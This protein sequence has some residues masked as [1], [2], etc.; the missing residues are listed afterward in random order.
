MKKRTLST[1][2]TLLAT[3]S[4]SLLSGNVLADNLPLTFDVY[5]AGP[6]SFH[7]NATLIVGETEALLVDT[8]FTKSD[9]LRIAAKVYDS[10]KPLKT[11]FISQADPDFYFG[12]ETLKQLFPDARVITTPAVRDIIKK[13]M[14]GK[15]DFWGPKLGTNAPQQP[16]LPDAYQGKT[17][18]LDGHTIEIRGTDG[19]LAHRPYLWIEDNKAIL[20]DI[21][22]FGGLH[23][24][25]ADTQTEEHL[26]G[27]NTQLGAM[28]S[29]NPKVVIP[30]HMATN[31]KLDT[32]SIHYSKTYL[33]QFR[34]AVKKADSS[35]DVKASMQSLYP[36]AGL[37]IALELGSKVHTG[38]MKW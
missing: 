5:N 10:G 16:V 32:S 38:E 4:L 36:N 13:K 20:G 35:D 2:A 9:A 12:A 28:L 23:L 19:V 8:G 30:G 31:T 37:G 17:L 21:A 1:A 7:V 11:I 24:W 18:T 3:A 14:A 25:T 22:V 26:N 29:L 27:W 34:Q 33:S 6:Q 15:V